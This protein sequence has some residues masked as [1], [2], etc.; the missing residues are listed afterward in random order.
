MTFAPLD[1]ASALRAG[2]ILVPLLQLVGGGLARYSG[3]IG[4]NPWF[5]A[6]TLPAWQPPGAVFGIAWT[7]LYVLLAVAAALIW[8]HRRAAG[9]TA[10]LALWA[11]QMVLNWGWSPLFFT[12]HQVLASTILIAVILIVSIATTFAFARISR[13]APWLMLPYLVW[14]SFALVLNFSLWQLNPG[15]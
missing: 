12:A 10:A 7:I 13:V 3:A 9:R 6:L 1:R 8:G 5:Q 2:I 15:V 14:L 11:L 4:Q